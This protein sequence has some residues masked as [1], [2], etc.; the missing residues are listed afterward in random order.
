MGGCSLFPCDMRERRMN[1]ATKAQVQKRPERGI[2]SITI[3]A[4]AHFFLHSLCQP[5]FHH[6]LVVEETRAGDSLDA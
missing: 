5:L 1:Q 3:S 4:A 6:G 2:L